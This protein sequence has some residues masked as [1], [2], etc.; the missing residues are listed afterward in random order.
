MFF[1]WMAATML[2]FF[3]LAANA[4]LSAA[5]S[6]PHLSPMLALSDGAVEVDG[7]WYESQTAYFLSDAFKESGRR[8]GTALPDISAKDL[9][10]L[11]ED[12]ADCTMEL[13]VI[14]DA[15]WPKGPLVIPVVFH[16]IM[17]TDGTGAVSDARINEQIAILNADFAPYLRFELAGVTRTV[18]D[19]WF[20]DWNEKEYKTA[21]AWDRERYMNVYTNSASGYLGYSYFPQEIEEVGVL[22]GVV[23]LHDTVGLNPSYAPYDLGRTLTHEIGHYLGLFHTFKHSFSEECENGYDR[24]DLIVDTPSESQAHY[25]CT[26]TMSCSTPDPIHNYMNYTPDVCM[27]QFTEEQFN[28]MI[29]SLLNYRPNLYRKGAAVPTG[30][31]I[32]WLSGL[33]LILLLLGGMLLRRKA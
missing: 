8:C 6:R 23:M 13:T 2:V 28:R 25:T 10:L 14:R 7:V 33:G 16:V 12:A 9:A 20:E 26:Q 27:N 30:D 15:Y 24:G 17:K 1:R 21:L 32:I 5:N 4:P 31:S 29:C 3:L 11:A 18:N 22:D 19:N